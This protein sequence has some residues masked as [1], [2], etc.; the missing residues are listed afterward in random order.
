MSKTKL[1]LILVI[2]F[3]SKV[4][5]GQS[6]PL[7]PRC[8]SFCSDSWSVAWGGEERQRDQGGLRAGQ[9][10]LEEAIGHKPV[11]SCQYRLSALPSCPFSVLSRELRYFGPPSGL[12]RCCPGVGEMLN[13]RALGS[14]GPSVGRSLW[15]RQRAKGHLPGPLAPGPNRVVQQDEGSWSKPGGAREDELYFART[16]FQNVHCIVT[17]SNLGDLTGRSKFPKFML[18]TRKCNNPGLVSQR[19]ALLGAKRWL[20]LGWFLCHSLQ[21]SWAEEIAWRNGPRPVPTTHKGSHTERSL[22]S[23]SLLSQFKQTQMQE[24]AGQVDTWRVGPAGERPALSELRV[25]PHSPA[26]SLFA[27]ATFP[28]LLARTSCLVA[29][30]LRKHR[31]PR[32]VHTRHMAAC[33]AGGLLDGPGYHLHFLG[34]AHVDSAWDQLMVTSGVHAGLS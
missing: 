8:T 11:G 14:T 1:F 32:A 30:C 29:S 24:E 17:I 9:S 10:H 13:A 20:L 18:N 21:G 19:A 31:A 25:T 15:R 27:T 3:W 5:Q 6:P 2:W 34:R 4:P 16:K 12:S 26:L 28:A 23:P 33:L 7:A 22:W